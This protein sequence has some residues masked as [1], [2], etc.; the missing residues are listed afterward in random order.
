MDRDIN[1]RVP[2]VQEISGLAL[3]NLASEGPC[4]MELRIYLV[5]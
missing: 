5:S 4:F 3:G 2:K 1:L